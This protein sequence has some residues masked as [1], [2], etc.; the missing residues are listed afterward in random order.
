[1]ASLN[2]SAVYAEEGEGQWIGGFC[3]APLLGTTLRYFI[4]EGTQAPGNLFVLSFTGTVLGF[5]IVVS[6]GGTA[7]FLGS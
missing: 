4:Y 3:Q 5:E 1:M 7:L 2:P 6:R